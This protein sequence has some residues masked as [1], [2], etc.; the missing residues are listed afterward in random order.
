MYCQVHTEW[1]RVLPGALGVVRAHS[2]T[3]FVNAP[4]ERGTV[5]PMELLAKFLPT[6]LTRSAAS[7]IE[8]WSQ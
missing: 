7:V 5:P 4:N 8:H 6:G 3:R 2:S 1:V